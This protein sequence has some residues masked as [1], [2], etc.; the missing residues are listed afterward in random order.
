MCAR[1]QM[2]PCTHACT[3]PQ[4]R[5][6]ALACMH[7]RACASARTH[8]QRTHAHTTHVS[9]PTQPLMHAQTQTPKNARTH[10]RTSFMVGYNRQACSQ[11][12]LC[13]Q[14]ATQACHQEKGQIKP[15]YSRLCGSLPKHGISSVRTTAEAGLGCSR[16]QPMAAR[17]IAPWP[18][19]PDLYACDLC[20]VTY[21]P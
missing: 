14:E 8:M 11:A 15:R 16:R 3:H 13:G 5:Q 21:S 1:A 10:A 2:H 20:P 6:H 17:R 12:C 4:T 7:T 19:A 9:L 18:I